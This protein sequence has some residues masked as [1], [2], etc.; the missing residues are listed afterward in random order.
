MFSRVVPGCF[1]NTSLQKLDFSSNKLISHIPSSLRSLKDILILDISS[2]ELSGTISPEVSNLRTII[3]LDLS[4]NQISGSIPK[5]M[6]SLQTLQN[7]S[8]A[9]NK[10]QW[11]IPELLGGKINKEFLDI[12]ENYFSDV[13]QGLK[14]MIDVATALEYLHHDS[15]T[16][17]VHCD[18]KPNNVLLDEDMVAHL[19]D[20][21]IAKLFGEGQLKS[22]TKTLATIGYMALEYGS[23]GV[24]TVKGDVYSYSILLME[25]FTRS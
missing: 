16:Q 12:S 23:K 18:V 22:Y 13:I 11:P 14:I 7:L 20:F 15:S 3:L 24:V 2:N 19:S 21:G 5:S 6:G 8:L 10:L 17:V 9:H 4:R 1:G 25:I